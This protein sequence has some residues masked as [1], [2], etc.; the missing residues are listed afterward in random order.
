MLESAPTY[1]EEFIDKLMVAAS[2]TTRVAIVVHL[3]QYLHEDD[4]KQLEHEVKQMLKKDRLPVFDWHLA[5]LE[6]AG[7]IYRRGLHKVYGLTEIGQKIFPILKGSFDK[8]V[9]TL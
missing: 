2:D 4:Y 7:I 3:G 6:D 8:V 5:R 1:Q 9:D